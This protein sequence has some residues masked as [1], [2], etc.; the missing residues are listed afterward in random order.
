[1]NIYSHFPSTHRKTFSLTRT[2][3]FQ[4]T[5]KRNLAKEAWVPLEPIL[6]IGQLHSHLSRSPYFQK[7]LTQ[8]Q[9]HPHNH[10]PHSRVLEVFTHQLERQLHDHSEEEVQ[11]EL[12]EH[13]RAHQFMRDSGDHKRRQSH[14]SHP[15]PLRG[16]RLAPV[17][18]D[19]RLDIDMS[20]TPVVNGSVP[21]L[22]ELQHRGGVPPVLVEQAVAEHGQLRQ[23]VQRA[24][25][26]GEEEQQPHQEGRERA[27]EDAVEQVGGRVAQNRVH[28][29]H[30][31]DVHQRE[32]DEHR[33]RQL[34][35]VA[36][37]D[38]FGARIGEFV[39]QRGSNAVSQ[40]PINERKT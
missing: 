17:P 8:K 19:L 16:Q 3:H 15:P 20:Q 36:Q 2:V 4:Q 23:Q 5:T 7:G 11:R 34:H 35:D 26:H 30:H 32:A 31:D 10:I 9:R 22:P 25:E 40:N 38:G 21:L 24:V 13:D 33:H 12:S 29:L 37:T 28:E 27:A 18:V 1:M 6:A 39:Q 14:N